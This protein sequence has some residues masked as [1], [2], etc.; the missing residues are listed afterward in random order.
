ASGLMGSISGSAVANVMTTGTF[1]IPLIKK[2]GYKNYEAA[3]IETAA[4]TGG[5]LV[6]PIMGAGAF[7][8]A[9]LTGIPYSK[10]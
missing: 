1:T 6:P 9:E 3:A 7:V 2:S 4:S 8:M 5:Q 10:I